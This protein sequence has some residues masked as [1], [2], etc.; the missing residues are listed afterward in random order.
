MDNTI[1]TLPSVLK[2]CRDH[3][4]KLIY[5]GSSTKF[6][7]ADSVYSL[8]KKANTEMVS[9]YCKSFDVDHAI[10]YFYNVYGPGETAQGKYSTV[11]AKFLDLKKQGK[12]AHIHSPGTQTRIFTHID[13]IISGLITVAE[14]GYG[15]NFGIGNDLDEYSIVELAKLI[16]VDYEVVDAVPGNRFF[17]G[18]KTEKTINLG[19]KSTH[20]LKDYLQ[21]L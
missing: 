4:A 9:F 12:K 8:A 2:Y 7:D 20:S 3:K 16:A 10:T 5:S 6:G 17:S 21:S 14:K 19:W 13:D 15:D 1:K 11:V 18:L